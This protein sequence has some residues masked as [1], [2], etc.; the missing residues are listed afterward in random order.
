MLLKNYPSR[1]TLPCTHKHCAIFQNMCTV[2]ASALALERVFASSSEIW[3][4]V[5]MYFRG[6]AA[7]N[8]SRELTASA[9]RCSSLASLDLI[10]SRSRSFRTPNEARRS[11]PHIWAK[12]QKPAKNEIFTKVVKLADLT[13]ACNDLTKLEFEAGNRKRMLW[14]FSETCMENLVKSPWVN[15]FFGGFSTFGTTVHHYRGLRH[16]GRRGRQRGQDDCG[17]VGVIGCTACVAGVGAEIC[18]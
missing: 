14:N 16:R 15:L 8:N 3:G 9:Q 13:C 12:L 7:S 5:R 17:R 4:C 18:I 2:A 10:E 11:P 1:L 6:P